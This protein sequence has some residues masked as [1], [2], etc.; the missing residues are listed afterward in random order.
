M[1]LKTIK[2][3]S[4]VDKKFDPETTMDKSTDNL[5]FNASQVESAYQASKNKVENFEKEGNKP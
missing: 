5:L 3:F 1:A 4:V 2:T